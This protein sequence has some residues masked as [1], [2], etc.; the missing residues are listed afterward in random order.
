MK[1]FVALSS[2]AHIGLGT[3]GLLALSGEGVSGGSI[4]SLAHGLVSPSL[5]LLYGGFL[6]RTFSTR[7]V[8]AYRGTAVLLPVSTTLGFLLLFA[9]IAVPLSSN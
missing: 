7:Q 5:F 4:L 1:A 9:N 8:Q 6:Y 3:I 2:V